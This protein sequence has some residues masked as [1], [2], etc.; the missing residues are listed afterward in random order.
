M[1]EFNFEY[2]DEKFTVKLL[3]LSFLAHA[4]LLIA[5]LVT[6]DLIGIIGALI[7][8]FGVPILIFLL[9]KK[10]IKKNGTANIYDSS[11]EFKLAG[12]IEQVVYKEI[13][14][15]QVERFNGTQLVIKLKDG[16][17]F[18][19]Q[20][21]SI[22]CNSDQFDIFCEELEK[23]VQQFKSTNNAELTLQP[24]IYERAWMLPFLIILTTGLIGRIVFAKF[25]EKSI[26]STF[27]TMALIVIPMW[28]VYFKARKRRKKQ[29]VKG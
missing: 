2:T 14:T 5:M 12:S 3:V 17:K 6:I 27:Y 28:I 25:Q 15:Y 7:L 13:K 19:L 16:K 20:A 8:A 29:Q 23:S 22:F 9:N 21:N 10:K 11:S 4:V 24:S 18:K 26:P 1:R